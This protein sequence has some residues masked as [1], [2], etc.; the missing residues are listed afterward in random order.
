[1]FHSLRLC[2]EFSKFIPNGLIINIIE[3]VI[4]F[5][6]D[7]KLYYV[8]KK[9]RNQKILDIREAIVL[10]SESYCNVSN[11]LLSQKLNLSSSMISKIRSGESKGTAY[12]EEVMRRWEE[13]S[14]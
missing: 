8:T 4:Y 13:I 14:K 5:S 2:K 10:L 9:I 12:V 6:R 11:K 3:R 1:M 7:I